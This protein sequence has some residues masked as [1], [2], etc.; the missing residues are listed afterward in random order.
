VVLAIS[1]AVS[2]RT[3]YVKPDGTGDAP[4]IQ[5]AIDMAGSGDIVELADGVFSGPGNRDLEIWS[6]IIWLRSRNGDPGL[7]TID[8]DGSAADPHFGLI[9]FGLGAA[10][11]W[12]E[13]I[14][15]REAYAGPYS[16]IRC[17]DTTFPV[18]IFDCVLTW[19][20]ADEGPAV[21]LGQSDDAEIHDCVFNENQAIGYRGSGGAIF[22]T[23]NSS[24]LVYRCTFVGNSASYLCSAIL[25]Q[26]ASSATVENC[27][28]VGNSTP[29]GGVIYCE[30]YGPQ[31][32]STNLN[33]VIIAWNDSY[34]A[35]C[36]IGSYV[37]CVCCDVYSNSGGDWWYCIAGQRGVNGNFLA[38]PSFC[39]AEMGDFQLCDESPCLPG[40][41][42]DGY[43]CGPI[44]AWGP[45]CSCGPS[46]TE[47]STWGSIKAMFR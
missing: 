44:G 11:G 27:T 13:G 33:N 5:A 28:F 39:H 15:I 4:T 6:K 40:N 16:A 24:A 38:C 19:N 35:G 2:A 7:C 18:K 23:A 31:A 10:G 9:F 42:P 30:G 1:S 20:R 32:S 26:D 29:S 43:D 41:H 12:V 3:W 36:G 8:C 46:E 25:V 45:G 21:Y 22:L 47:P 34:A 17:W 14:T 37:T